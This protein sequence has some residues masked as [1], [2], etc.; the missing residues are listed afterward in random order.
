MDKI[1][2]IGLTQ[3]GSR[4]IQKIMDRSYQSLFYNLI[5]LIQHF[6]SINLNILCINDNGSYLVIKLIELSDQYKLQLQQLKSHSQILNPYYDFNYIMNFIKINFLKLSSNKN[7][8]NIIQKCIEIND[9]RILFE[10]EILMNYLELLK[11]D[12]S[13]Y[14]IIKY[15][16]HE[17]S[18]KKQIV[19]NMV[20]KS[21][22]YNYVNINYVKVLEKL[23]EI[24]SDNYLDYCIDFLVEIDKIVLLAQYP[25]CLFSN[26]ILF[27]S[28]E[29]ML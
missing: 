20:L 3:Y 15:I 16:Y 14:V 21:F 19:L 18:E 29:E 26:F 8:T 24:L 5:V 10:D 28:F 23:I 1:S 4:C 22:Y 2:F 13:S 9:Y 6:V 25:S 12:Y 27:F 11:V 17:N 7:G